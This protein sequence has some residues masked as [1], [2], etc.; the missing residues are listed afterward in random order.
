[1]KK[2]IPDELLPLKY[3]GKGYLISIDCHVYGVRGHQLKENTECDYGLNPPKVL[4][5]N[6]WWLYCMTFYGKH[7]T[8]T[9]VIKHR[10]VPIWCSDELYYHEVER[11]QGYKPRKVPLTEKQKTYI[12]MNKQM[13]KQLIADVLGVSR[14][15][16][17]RYIKELND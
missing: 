5:R 4:G 16:I 17:H 8:N 1:M 6:L 9:K 10:D 3:R 2:I 11:H 7:E 15:T 14:M 12:K 13:P